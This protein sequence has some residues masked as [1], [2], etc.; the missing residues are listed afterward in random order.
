MKLMMAE[1]HLAASLSG[2]WQGAWRLTV[3][4]L[5]RTLKHHN[6]VVSGFHKIASQN[7]SC[8]EVNQLCHRQMSYSHKIVWICLS[9]WAFVII[10]ASNFMLRE[11]SVCHCRST[12][13]AQTDGLKL[14]ANINGTQR[15]IL[16]DSCDPIVLSCHH[17]IHCLYFK[18][19][20]SA[21]L[22]W[23]GKFICK[24]GKFIDILSIFMFG[25]N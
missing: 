22:E 19:N 23:I 4:R 17:F 5:S 10:L 8:S 3:M 14:C 25:A 13:L 1:F 9:V 18:W 21:T 24:F 7:A 20:V 2:F 16:H 11:M 6:V 12:T 15:M